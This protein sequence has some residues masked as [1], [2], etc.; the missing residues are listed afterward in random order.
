[1]ALVQGVRR[2]VPSTIRWR[3]ESG[4]D[5]ARASHAPLQDAAPDD[6]IERLLRRGQGELGLDDV[7]KA[8]ELRPVSLRGEAEG[9]L[10]DGRPLLRG[11]GETAGGLE[12]EMGPLHFV[13]HA[14]QKLSPRMPLTQTQGIARAR[15]PATDNLDQ[16]SPTK[17]TSS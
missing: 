9:F 6:V 11:A 12:L 3:P 4:W 5:A 13:A 14:L 15:Q 8:S 1:M 17:R 2:R 10:G 16:F 7:E